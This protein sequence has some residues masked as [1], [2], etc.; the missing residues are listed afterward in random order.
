MRTFG[1]H[2]DHFGGQKHEFIGVGVGVGAVVPI[3]LFHVAEQLL[4][5]TAIHILFDLL[6]YQ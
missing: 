4:G 5:T 3:Q 6:Q 1:H 2:S